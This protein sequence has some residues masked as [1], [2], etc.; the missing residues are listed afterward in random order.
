MGDRLPGE[1]G[2]GLDIDI[3]SATDDLNHLNEQIDQALKDGDSQETIDS[4]KAAKEAKDKEIRDLM[5]KQRARKNAPPVKKVEPPKP[6]VDDGIPRTVERP[7]TAPAYVFPSDPWEQATP[8][9]GQPVGTTD[10]QWRRMQQEM[11]RLAMRR[12]YVGW[13]GPRVQAGEVEPD[14]PDAYASLDGPYK[15]MVALQQAVNSG[16]LSEDL[17]ESLKEL[18]TADGLIALG[19][20]T[21]LFMAAE[22]AGGPVAWFGSAVALVTLY[23]A[24]GQA[25]LDL[26]DVMINDVVDA[27]NKRQFDL[28][29][30]KLSRALAGVGS[31]WIQSFAAMVL[32]LCGRKVVKA[33]KARLNAP[34]PPPVTT[35][36]PAP[37]KPVNKLGQGGV[38]EAVP[39]T[40]AVANAEAVKMAAPINQPAVGEP[41]GHM[42]GRSV[43]CPYTSMVLADGFRGGQLSGM[44]APPGGV[45]NGCRWLERYFGAKFKPAS[46]ASITATIAKGG[47]GAQGIVYV[48]WAKATAHVFNV[49]NIGG[50]VIFIDAQSGA[51]FNPRYWSATVPHLTTL[52]VIPPR[53]LPRGGGIPSTTPVL[54]PRATTGGRTLSRRGVAVAGVAVVAV[55]A[56]AT[57]VV[58][59]QAGLGSKQPVAAVPVASAVAKPGSGSGSS[60]SQISAAVP[61]VYSG[62]FTLQDSKCYSSGYLFKYEEDYLLKAGDGSTWLVNIVPDMSGSPGF[63]F[64]KQTAA[65]TPEEGHTYW[66]YGSGG[67]QTVTIAPGQGGMV[68]HDLYPIG[69]NTG[70]PA[71]HL[72][73]TGTCPAGSPGS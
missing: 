16:Q 58:T 5:R 69:V 55:G 57:G 36:P 39:P 23:M 32:S 48:K 1:S 38:H 31:Q 10:E 14:L 7:G 41:P 50:H 13:R 62:N 47:P 24:F 12:D 25:L 28:A 45:D 51:H 49:V 20:F 29:V 37:P 18:V 30:A 61:G 27:Q 11:G 33:V 8:D 6:S 65:G 4:L 53:V 44:K 59:H 34:E 60:F 21:A 72:K 17:A 64:A 71:G 46:R 54:R 67:G 15:V 35:P 73:I 52:M 43:N 42:G 66:G 22:A 9:A 56:V 3:S 19:T 70:P 68:D 2:F 26:C 63:F 40:E